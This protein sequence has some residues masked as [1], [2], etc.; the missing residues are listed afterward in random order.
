MRKLENAA[1]ELRD[2]GAAFYITRCRQVPHSRLVFGGQLLQ[3]LP[4]L[5]RMPASARSDPLQLLAAIS[6]SKER[7]I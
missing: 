2:R 3:L 1:L 6:I 7:Q 4:H 5:V